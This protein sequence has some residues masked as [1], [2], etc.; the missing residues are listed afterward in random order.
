MNR[1][2][3]ILVGLSDAE[4]PSL[5]REVLEIIRS[6]RIFSGGARHRAIVEHLLP[7]GAQWITITPPLAQLYPEYRAAD[8]VVIFTSGDPLF[9]GFAATLQR[10]IPEAELTIYPTFHSLQHLAHRAKLP[11]H[12]MRHVSLTGRDWHDFYAA[13]MAEEPMIG[14][15]TDSREHTPS[16]IARE[17]L[18]WGFSNYTMLLGTC[19]GNA[20][21]EK[22][23]ELPLD[24][25]AEEH[26]ESPNCLILR[27][28]APLGLTVGIPEELF[29]KLNARERMI[30]K[31][32]VR[33]LTLSYLCLK[34]NSCFWDVGFCTGS[35]SIEALRF[36][37]SL[38]VESF[39]IRPECEE[40]LMVNARRFHT[41]GIGVHMGDFLS[42]DLSGIPSPDA[43]FI[44]GHGGQLPALMARLSQQLSVG[45]KL[46][47][48]ASSEENATLFQR[49]VGKCGLRL[50][51]RT[52]MVVDV[53]NRIIVLQAEKEG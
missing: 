5:D 36:T 10:E 20:E 38:R 29:E 33:L 31:M 22:V 42:C 21:R 40:L 15:L 27:Q 35:V 25:V 53:Y 24:R 13:L 39:E 2:H 16:A 9:Y 8:S 43:A 34:P 26:D 50:L 30:T 45:G 17:M 19:L 47:F 52:E 44:G 4:Q 41:P 1:L 49:L 14:V 48:N 28:Q 51:K 6:S 46:V 18:A 3:F 7:E 37:P 23:R 12:S 32:P 11:Y